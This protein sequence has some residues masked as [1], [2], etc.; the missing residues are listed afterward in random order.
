MAKKLL[1]TLENPPEGMHK[2]QLFDDKKHLKEWL[3]Q[4]KEHLKLLEVGDTEIT[5]GEPNL[6]KEGE[7]DKDYKA[8]LKKEG[9]GNIYTGTIKE[10]PADFKN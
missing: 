2:S 8:R 10:V 4:N 5:Y 9:L 3:E 6:Q 7:K 1:L